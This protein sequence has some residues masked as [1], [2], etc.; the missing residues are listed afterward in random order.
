MRPM[1][2]PAAAVAHR[3]PFIPG[4]LFE[5]DLYGTPCYRHD[6]GQDFLPLYLTH[7][8]ETKA[9]RCHKRR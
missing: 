1:T 7:L 2:I 8:K 3:L 6:D 5:D 9:L 4:E